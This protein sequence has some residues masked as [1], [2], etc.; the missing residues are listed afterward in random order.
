MKLEYLLCRSAKHLLTPW[1]KFYFD[2]L[3]LKQ[4]K[5][6]RKYLD[7]CES[8]MNDNYTQKV[9]KMCFQNKKI[10]PSNIGDIRPEFTC[11][12]Y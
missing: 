3:C 1:K 4:N 11:I 2:L 9:N 12:A 7:I 8:M 6:I 10:L 5:Y